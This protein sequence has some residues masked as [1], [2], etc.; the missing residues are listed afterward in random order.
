MNENLFTESGFSVPSGFKGGTRKGIR[1]SNRGRKRKAREISDSDDSDGDNQSYDEGV[2]ESHSEGMSI[3]F[4]KSIY[5]ILSVYSFFFQEL[6]Y[7]MS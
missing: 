6:R 4:F 5:R 7:S 1:R 2:S 3:N